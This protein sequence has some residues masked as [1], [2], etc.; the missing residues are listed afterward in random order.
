[1]KNV[2]LTTLGVLFAL[3]SAFFLYY[4]VRLVLM[5]M[6]AADAAAHRTSGM[7]IGAIAFPIATFVFGIISRLCF[8]NRSRKVQ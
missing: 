7:L 6:F 2:V 8:K 5:N 1:M 3:M 4:T